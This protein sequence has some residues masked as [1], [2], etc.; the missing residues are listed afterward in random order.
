MS[1]GTHR[2][3]LERTLSVHI[4]DGHTHVVM[5]RIDPATRRLVSEDVARRPIGE[6]D[7]L[8]AMYDALRD[9]SELLASELSSRQLRLL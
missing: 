1:T 3:P 5:S 9:A 7:P 8:V 6:E 4:C 2:S